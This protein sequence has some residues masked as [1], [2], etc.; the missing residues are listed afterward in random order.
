MSRSGSFKESAR[1]VKTN[2]VMP[3]PESGGSSRGGG[4]S[5][6]GRG[7]EVVSGNSRSNSDLVG[8]TSVKAMT[9][10][11]SIKAMIQPSSIKAVTEASSMKAIT[12]LDTAFGESAVMNAHHPS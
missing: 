12:Q 11:S 10:P 7:R 4:G 9:Q 1:S 2:Q 5:E 8:S 3:L 6:R